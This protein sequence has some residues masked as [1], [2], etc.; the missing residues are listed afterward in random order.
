MIVN[1]MAPR[2]LGLKDNQ[3]RKFIH[4]RCTNLPFYYKKKV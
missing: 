4:N 2:I 1:K 3:G